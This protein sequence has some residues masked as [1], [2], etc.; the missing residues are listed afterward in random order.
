MMTSNPKVLTLDELRC[1]GGEGKILVVPVYQ[2]NFAWTKSEIAQLI[3]DIFN[4]YEKSKSNETKGDYYLG[5][6]ILS[7]KDG[8]KFEIIDGQQRLIALY[9]ICLELGIKPLALLEFE[10]REKSTKTLKEWRDRNVGIEN[11]D[12][13]QALLEGRDNVKRSLEEIVPFF[14][15]ESDKAE[16]NRFIEF[17]FNHVKVVEY[18]VP[19]D[20]DL[21]HYF[22]VMNSRGVQLE[23]SEILKARLL[24]TIK[25][26]AKSGNTDC[27]TRAF[28]LIWNASS[29]MDR[30]VQCNAFS[31]MEPC[32]G[33]KD[34]SVKNDVLTA[35]FGKNCGR[36]EKTDFNKIA[37]LFKN[38]NAEPSV[39]SNN[40]PSNEETK[41]KY[42][43]II[44]ILSRVEDHL[45]NANDEVFEQFVPIIDF[46]NFLLH[47]LKLTVLEELEGIDDNSFPLS[48]KEFE[49]KDSILRLFKDY[50]DSLHNYKTKD[51]FIRSVIARFSLD[52]KLLI[53]QFERYV[54]DCA[55][56]KKFLFN[57]L[58]SRFCLDNFIVHRNSSKSDFD[59]ENAWFVQTC[60]KKSE[61]FKYVDFCSQYDDNKEIQSELVNLLSMFQ[62]TYPQKSGKNFLFYCLLFLTNPKFFLGSACSKDKFPLQYRDFLL[63]L[64]S[65][66]LHAVYLNEAVLYDTIP[67]PVSFDDMVLFEKRTNFQIHWHCDNPMPC[68]VID[69]FFGSEKK[70]VSR[71]SAFILNYLDFLIWRKATQIHDDFTNRE[72]R[73]EHYK[74]VFGCD[75]SKFEFSVKHFSFSQE[76]NTLEH[77]LAQNDESLKDASYVDKVKEGIFCLGNL[78][79]IGS[80][81][82]SKGNNRNIQN[83]LDIYLDADKQKFANSG[84]A[85]LKLGI[86]MLLSMQ[87]M[88]DRKWTKDQIHTHQRKMLEL[89]FPE[90]KH[91]H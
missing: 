17:T 32:L 87:N 78:A 24:N 23:Q 5:T 14:S 13:D 45:G 50:G 75:L 77:F 1:Q 6:L 4:F 56:V 67:K 8:D 88:Q 22:E 20:T 42:R 59:E 65:C 27:D 36:F 25:T 85:S 41:S 21:N 57:L 15:E 62:V 51:D 53:K 84:V 81:M 19:H 37:D 52:D 86:M 16:F 31:L 61:S 34:S 66:Y 28:N 68:S 43:E 72:D 63:D 11:E 2:R 48:E 60:L 70:G 89:L 80:R 76:R 58:K 44:A 54:D 91:L 35:I 82:N 29:R 74:N 3:S 49:N 38:E 18:V 55:F 39:E 71:I 46:P 90:S 40:D 12:Y 30:Y 33:I 10:A 26:P 7:K 69:K 79:L 9:L 64:A 83:K 73:S 47:V